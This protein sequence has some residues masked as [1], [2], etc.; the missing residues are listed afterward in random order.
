MPVWSHKT[1]KCVPGK[2]LLSKEDINL[3]QIEAGLAWHNKIYQKQQS[4]EDRE[5]YAKAEEEAREAKRGLW[6]EPE[7]VPPWERRKIKRKWIY[8]L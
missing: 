2:V 8:V 7:P 5:A 3:K 1:T 4:P 6:R